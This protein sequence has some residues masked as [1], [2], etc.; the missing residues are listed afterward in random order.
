MLL[1]F[2][3]D[4]DSEELVALASL[5]SLRGRLSHCWHL[6]PRNGLDPLTAEVSA[7]QKSGLSSGNCRSC[8]CLPSHPPRALTE[9]RE[10]TACHRGICPAVLPQSPLTAISFPPHPGRSHPP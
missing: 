2:V 4:V 9:L 7:S 3:S 1:S 8:H 10:P 5:E 6:L